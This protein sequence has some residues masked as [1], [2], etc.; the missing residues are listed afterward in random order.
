MR[1]AFRY[2]RFGAITM[3]PL[4]AGPRFSSIDVTDTEIMVRLGWAFRATIPRSSVTE[5]IEP[6]QRVISRGAH[7][8]SGRWLVNGAGD[9][10]VTIRLDP[11]ARAR[12][13]GFPVTVREL[14]V[15]AAEPDAL[16]TALTTAG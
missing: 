3:S 4:G 9:G 14:I 12:V 13:L 2:D 16:V 8:W 5:V 1:F 11:R 15:S 10:L 7:G 6:T